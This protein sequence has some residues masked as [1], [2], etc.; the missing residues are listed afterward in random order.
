MMVL[1]QAEEEI[2]NDPAEIEG[3]MRAK[4]RLQPAT[5]PSKMCCKRNARST[6]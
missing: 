5:K 2:R 4:A 6:L 3:K 1:D